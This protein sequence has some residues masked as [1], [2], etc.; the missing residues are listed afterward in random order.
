MRIKN[1]KKVLSIILIITVLQGIFIA[2]AVA[3]EQ[4]LS[5]IKTVLSS[6]FGTE[7]EEQLE[8]TNGKM[9]DSIV[10]ANKPPKKEIDTSNIE[11]SE[12]V[13]NNI[14]SSDPGNAEKNMRN[15]KKLL[16]EFNV[17]KQFSQEIEKAIKN[18]Y[19]AP[20]IFAAY[21]F[22]NE[23]YGQISELDELLKNKKKGLPWS[24][25]FKEYEDIH[26][27][28][29]P[30][31]FEAG[32]IEKLLKD[33]VLTA[34]DVMIADRISQK[35]LKG[36]EELLNLRKEGK[37]WAE[38]NIGLGIVNMQ[39]KFPRFAVTSDQVRVYVKTRGLT[40]DQVINAIVIA[41]K[42]E[43]EEDEIIDKVKS[44]KKKEDI[45]SLCYEEKYK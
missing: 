3:N 27:E 16:A 8:D 43:R 10:K 24:D 20:D 34:D 41:Q 13:L 28:F 35:G 12:E 38:I 42:M 33:S 7:P 9:K 14:R 15:Y 30:R 1:M 40:E 21:D 22:L 26:K 11:V 23:N 31:N 5:A 17:D 29:K 18:G 44:G 4:K 2:Y 37:T 39:S 6:V 36:F 45:Y 19:N 32:V 25:V